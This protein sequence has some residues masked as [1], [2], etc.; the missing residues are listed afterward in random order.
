MQR[1]G[2]R[3]PPDPGCV[4][5]FQLPPQ[6]PLVL[7]EQREGD[8]YE[9]SVVSSSRA[10]QSPLDAPNATSI[11]T[12]QDIRLSGL[13]TFGGAFWEFGEPDWNHTRYFLLF[14]VAEDHGSNPIKAGLGN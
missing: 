4:R 12:A 5:R 2:R 1:E 11:I 9:E 14:G 7:G 10:A 13:Y 8:T 6:R 3:Q